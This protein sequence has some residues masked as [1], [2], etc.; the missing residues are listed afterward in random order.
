M[1]AIMHASDNNTTGQLTKGTTPRRNVGDLERALSAVG[2]GALALLALR[3][4]GVSGFAMGIAGAELLRRGATGHCRLYQA[5][6][7]STTGADTRERN[8]VTGRAATVNARK[9]VKIEQHIVVRRPAAELYDLWRDFSVLP[10]FMQHLD[11]VTCSDD[12]HSHWLARLPGGKEVEWDAEIVNDLEGK[13]IAWKTVGSPDIA[14]AGSVHFTPLAD[15]AATEVRVVFDY[16]PPA[17]RTFGVI[18]QHL[19][20]SPQTLVAEDLRRFKDAAERGDLARVVTQSTP[21][22]ESPG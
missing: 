4:R 17:A 7:V 2:G 10:R 18:A 9:A 21:N 13:L 15:M 12:R 16:E 8:D 11:S 1:G 3:K 14:H 19:G 5:L 6:G 22:V 20:L